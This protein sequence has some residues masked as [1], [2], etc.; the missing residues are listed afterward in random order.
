MADRSS[1]VPSKLK[2]PVLLKASAMLL[3]HICRTE[4]AQRLEKALDACADLTVGP[5][6][7]T[8]SQ[9]AEAVMQNL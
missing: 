3:R 1:V 7:I 2:F 4:A 8:G 9:Y 5:D 6:G